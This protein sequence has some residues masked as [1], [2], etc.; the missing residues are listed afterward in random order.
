M[1]NTP[2]ELVRL[3][4]DKITVLGDTQAAKYFDVSRGTIISWRNLTTFPSIVAAQKVWDESLACRTPETWGKAENVPLQVLLP[5]YN[6][7]EPMNHI[8]LMA[9]YRHYGI[10]K[11][12]GIPKL[13]TLID[14]ARNDLA[15]SF[16]NASHSE[17]CLFVDSDMVLPIGNAA[18]LRKH[19]WNVPDLQGNR[20]AFERIMSWGPEYQ[21]IG[22]L[23]RDRRNGTRAQCERAFRSTGENERLISIIEGRGGNDGPEENG[24]VATGFLRIHR[25]VFEAM[26]KEARPGGV[27]EDIAPPP[28]R[29]KD[30]IGFFGR[31]AKYRGEDVALG[32]RAGML[33]IRSWVD[34][35]L[36]LGHKGDKI[37]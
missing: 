28:G 8:T 22:G 4:L 12:N 1:D 20:Y 18:V 31:S 14:E 10:D 25:S 15:H 13:R 2:R 23:Y 32:R 16:M 3:V 35:G 24:W 19:G 33:G 34:T 6:Q 30:P 36:L 29:E 37:Y 17:Y 21:I 5:I 11:I 9:N 27:L 26:A 7:V